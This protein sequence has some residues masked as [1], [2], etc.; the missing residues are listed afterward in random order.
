MQVK[1]EVMGAKTRRTND[2]ESYF[3]VEL[4][5]PSPYVHVTI[6]AAGHSL[7]SLAAFGAMLVGV[8]GVNQMA[9]GEVEKGRYTLKK[10]REIIKELEVKVNDLPDVT[11]PGGVTLKHA[12]ACVA[13]VRRI[14]EGQEAGKAN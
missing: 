3:T 9:A 7:A 5:E 8:Q 13:F 1:A 14:T 11:L 4:P 2:R 10:A 12:L 6:G